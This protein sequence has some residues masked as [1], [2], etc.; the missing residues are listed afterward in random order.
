MVSESKIL[1]KDYKHYNDYVFKSI[2]QK[3][4]NGLLEFV[5]IPHKIYRFLISEYTNLGPSISRLDFVGES[6]D[7]EK[8]LILIFECQTKLP[9]DEDIKRF[10]QYVASIRVFKDSD[11]ELYILCT[12][13]PSYDKKEFRIKE[14][15]I[16]TMHVI[17]LKNF[18]AE[19]IFISLENKLKNNDKITDEDIASLQL[20]IYTDFKESKLVILNKARKLLEKISEKL[21][22]DINEKLAIIYLFDVLSTNMLNSEEHEKYVEENRMLLN[23]V[24][25][26]FKNQGIEEGIKKGIEEGIKKGIEE[27]IEEG[28][29][30]G[31][32][33]GKLE[34]ARN[35]LSEGDSV[36]K[37]VKVTGLSEEEILN[38]K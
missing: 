29:E 28:I 21:V 37:V 33:K 30:K 2:L 35:L 23:P 8:S 7:N 22:F 34:T 12:E 24:E 1:N 14:G 9:T 15:C 3:R 10:F 5:N 36:E 38:S 18:K 16:Y 26:Y 20:I 17:S 6:I 31:I 13:K 19:E 4:A 25:R 11:V 27:G 32:E